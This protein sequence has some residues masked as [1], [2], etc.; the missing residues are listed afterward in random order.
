MIFS[1]IFTQVDLKSLESIASNQDIIITKPDKDRG[2][3][4][5]NKN[6]YI[7]SM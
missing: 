2:V 7:N 3:V 5:V 4:I 6:N 1:P